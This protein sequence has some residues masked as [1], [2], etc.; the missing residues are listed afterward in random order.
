MDFT[1]AVNK[2][3]AEYN[4]FTLT[5]NSGKQLATTDS[6]LLDLFATIGAMRHKTEEQIKLDFSKAYADN[7]LLATRMAFYARDIRHGGLGERRT[8]RTILNWMGRYDLG[9]MLANIDLI[10]YFGRFDDLFALIGTQAENSMWEYISHTLKSD[11]ENSMLGLPTTQLAKWMPS[12]NT[13]SKTTR[14]L[15]KICAKRLSFSEKEYRLLLSKLRSHI[16]IVERKMTY[17]R[18]DEINYPAVPSQ[19]MRIYRNAFFRHS[20]E[21]YAKYMTQ[22]ETGTAKIN[23]KTLYPYDILR[24]Y[25]LRYG[26]GYGYC[27][28]GSFFV[29][30][31]DATLEEQWKA[32]PNYISGENNVLVMS[33]TSGSMSGLPI[34]ISI[35]LAIYFAERNSGAYKD[36]FL[37]FSGNP[38]FIKLVGTNLKEKVECIDVIIDNTDIEKAF[39][40]ILETAIE[41][42]VSQSEMPKALIVITDM[43]FDESTNGD[44]S[45]RLAKKKF[46]DVGYT[47]PAVIFWNV[48]QRTS[49]FQVKANADNVILVSGSSAG[50]FKNILNNIGTTP[51]EYMVNI[52][53]SEPYNQINLG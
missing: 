37:T 45:Y 31:F 34:S 47:L 40:L 19:A 7:P 39:D 9:T 28:D 52:L 38:K 23:A 51:Y 21:K 3:M 2:T 35:S 46:D 33:D 22:V 53:N 42:R 48:S 26:L 12:I 29:G 15:A 11:M 24:Q 17:N 6:P 41:N 25:G 50:T 20:P 36:L 1:Q 44:I 18:W 4:R 14:A 10:P 16:D 49:G 43:E 13:S 32:L 27:R 8:F 30:N 5:E